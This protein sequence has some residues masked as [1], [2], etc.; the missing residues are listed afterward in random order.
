MI[1]LNIIHIRIYVCVCVMHTSEDKGLT[2][3]RRALLILAGTLCGHYG[4][5]ARL[6]DLRFRQIL[7][8]RPDR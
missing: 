1:F 2:K 4:Q 8:A 6:R 3:A 5:D 7:Q